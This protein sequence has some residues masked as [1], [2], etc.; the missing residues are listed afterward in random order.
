MPFTSFTHPWWASHF[1]LLDE[2]KNCDI[3]SR[4]MKGTLFIIQIPLYSLAHCPRYCQPF[5]TPGTTTFW[6]IKA[7]SKCQLT[8]CVCAK[9]RD[10][11]KSRSL[12][13]ICP[14]QKW[15]P[16]LCQSFLCPLC[17]PFACSNPIFGLVSHIIYLHIKK[18]QHKT[19]PVWKIWPKRWVFIKI[20][21]N[22]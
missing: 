15:P 21:E 19:K 9:M 16:R 4:A 2:A 22:P 12:P 8:I 20:W 5:T 1:F 10:G 18:N 6:P 17:W 3:L 7:S 13:H 14:H 11:S